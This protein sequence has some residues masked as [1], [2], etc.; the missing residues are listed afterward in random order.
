MDL[1]KVKL[2]VSD[3]DGTLLNAKGE[4]SQLFFEVFKILQKNKV[5]FVAASGRQYNSI[6]QKLAPIKDYITVIAENGAIAKQQNKTLLL[7]KLPS[8]KLSAII[9]TLRNIENAY[10]V[11]CS[12]NTAYIE[13]T[14]KTFTALFQEYYTAFKTV[15]DLTKIVSDI[16]F[17]KIAVYH[18]KSSETYIY[19]EVRHLE[20]DF[21]LKISGQNWLDISTA[22]A[23]KGTALQFVQ[24][25]LGVTKEETLVFGDYHNDLEMLACADFSFAMKNAHSDIKKAANYETDS[26]NDFGVEKILQQVVAAKQK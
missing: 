8:K 13:S 18:L 25:Q 2:V 7:N 22:K 1:S 21:L 26:H 3:M 23:N 17:L 24:K 16:D 5:H 11:L 9:N 10:I 4:V 19:P 12:E 20:N 14:N 15:E 6:V